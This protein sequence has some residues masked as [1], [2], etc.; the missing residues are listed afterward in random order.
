MVT[1]HLRILHD[2]TMDSG[3]SSVSIIFSTEWFINFGDGDVVTDSGI[4]ITSSLAIQV[5]DVSLVVV[6]YSFSG[7]SFLVGFVCVLYCTYM[8]VFE[9]H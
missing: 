7:T 9:H 6:A 4:R 2:V 3:V 8:Y 1:L 5:D